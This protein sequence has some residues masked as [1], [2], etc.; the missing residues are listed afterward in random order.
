MTKF[1]LLLSRYLTVLLIFIAAV[2]SAQSRTVSGKVTSADDG[3]GMPGVSISEKGTSN[4]VITDAEG[5]YTISVGPNAVLVFSFVGTVTQ[6]IP[7]GN[8]TSIAVSLASDVTQL[9]EVVVVG[10]GTIERKD[11]TGSIVAVNSKD[12]NKGVMGSPQDLLLGKVAGVTI[13]SNSGAPGSSST[14]RIRG[15]S[16]LRASN[17][18]LIVIDGFP[19]DN[20]GVSGSPN[21][22]S[23]INPN[24]IE[25]FTVLKDASATAI[26]GSRASNGVILITTK[27]GSQDKMKI[28]YNGTVSF[29]KGM[30][31]V[32]VLTGD[33]VRDLATQ[34]ESEGFSGLNAAALARLGTENT[35]WQNEIYRTAVSS[36][37]NIGVS[38]A[39][40]NFPYRV[41]L[42]HTNQQGILKGTDMTR[43][44][45]DLK[46]NPSFLNNSLNVTTNLKTSFA[47]HSFGNAGAVGAAVAFDPTQ[48]VKNGNERYGG[49]FTWTALDQALPDGSNNPEGDRNPIGVSNPVALIDQTHNNSDV[50]RLLGNIMVDYRL[51]FFT[52]VVATVNAG[53]DRQVGEGYNRTDDDA[54]FLAAPNRILTEYDQTNVSKLLDIYFNYRKTFG[55]HKVD[56]T[57]GYSWQHFH[58]EGNSITSTEDGS[59]VFSEFPYKNENFLVSF[60]GRAQYSLKEKYLAYLTIRTDGSSRFAEENR[61]GFFPAV[62]LA[63][64]I[65]EEM[66]LKDVS[67]ISNLKLRLGYGITGQ[68]DIGGNYYPYLPTYRESIQGASYQFGDEFFNTLR[69]GAYDANIKWEETTTYNVGLDFGVLDNRITGAVEVYKRVT[70]DLLNFVPIAAGSNFSNFLD[71]NVGT[72][73]NN[74][75]EFTLNSQVIKSDNFEWNF[76]F[77][78]AHNKNEITK[79]TLQDDPNYPGIAVGGI[80]GGVGNTVQ[81][82]QVGYPANSFFVFQQVYGSDGRPL[83]GIYVDRSG[84][85]GNV[86][87]NLLNRYQYEKPAADVL[88]GINTSLR[89]KNFDLFMAGRVSIGNYVYNNVASDRAVYSSLYNQSGFFNNLPTA[90]NDSKFNNP[91]YFSD[92][93]VENA[94]FF[95]MDN[96][97]LGYSVN[98]LFT[99]KLNARFSFTVQNAF[100]ITKYSGLDPE[101]DGGIDNNF[102]PRP[103]TFLIGINL[104]Y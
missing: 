61:W 28:F 57:A 97:S 20:G 64:N 85:G 82:H 79:L 50:N 60:F 23:T 42:G 67:T 58:R 99:E 1:Y 3:S 33:E 88:F 19:V 80:S 9:G 25:T 98:E 62:A 59:D 74:G 39:V 37:H 4:G 87:A 12:F 11:V 49:Y 26:Y 32:D 40:K 51:P 69:P 2:A 81:V 83:E 86:T 21:V 36:D 14:I 93:Y 13:T 31:N 102:Y 53:I 84:E 15:G 10:Y 24:D 68:Q 100:F 52:D 48:P 76:G 27:K 73:E 30:K 8:Q 16:S 89:Y 65:S 47:K 5:N 6:E 35:D 91:Q 38:G 94:S 96:M 44:T 66:F 78:V 70:E 104:T 71:T 29:S 90:V 75:I 56:V 77:N 41:S 22:L 45:I 46:L 92:F 55:S 63:W 34:L 95:K 18:P 72:L 54:G 43:N 7:V 101:V 103:R 17:D